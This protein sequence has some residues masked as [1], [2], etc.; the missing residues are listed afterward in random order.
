MYTLL[1]CMYTNYTSLGGKTFL[2]FFYFPVIALRRKKRKIFL[3]FSVK[4]ENRRK[5]YNFSARP[6]KGERKRIADVYRCYCRVL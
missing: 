2:F 6:G 3:H 1:F 4:E 5:R